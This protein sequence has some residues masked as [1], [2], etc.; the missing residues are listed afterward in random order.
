MSTIL[1]RPLIT[2]TGVA[3]VTVLVVLA[4]VNGS[5]SPSLSSGDGPAAA[6]AVSEPTTE[7]RVLSLEA[8]IEAGGAK[9]QTYA[10]LG[11]LRLQLAGETTD[12]SL[13]SRAEEAFAEANQRDPSSHD[14]TVGLGALALAR[15]D[16]R[17]ALA[18]GKRARRLHPNSF[19]P[20]AILVD[21]ELELGRY[22]AV[23]RDLQRMVD[24]KP[25]LSSYARVSYFR[26][27]QG[28]LAGA[29]EAMKLAAAV[30]SGSNNFGY[31][32]ALVGKLEF[33]RGRY[34]A[35]EHAY[36]L[37][38]QADP[39]NAAAI[40]GLGA[41]DAAQGNN[42]AALRHYR[43]AAEAS[44]ISDYPQAIADLQ[45]VAGRETA[46]ERGYSRA[47]ALIRREIPYRVD[48]RAELALFLAEHG[49]ADKAVAL[50]RAALKVRRSVVGFDSLAWSLHHARMHGQALAASRQAMKLGS[51]DPLFLFR[52]GMIS[53]GAGAE[54]RAQR[55]LGQ[56]LRQSPRFH[57][58]YAP[59]A[60]RALA[61]L[62]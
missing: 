28:D 12:P 38:L 51:R 30:G 8:V 41:V 37:A 49:N 39:G 23:E 26:E 52:A 20:F 61:R 17:T 10:D 32:Q 50:S 29:I 13:Y 56:L 21:A 58:L 36:R 62:R 27:L 55:L 4:L 53:A 57:P 31:V 45:A 40:G 9:A 44:P 34:G 22:R 18:Y 7:D 6:T 15:H 46:A 60:R 19:A 33:D 59:Q 1:R 47:E 43:T 42:P 25:T 24:F 3:F 14:A 48:V 11:T 5:S 54:A 2:T 16:F 35:A